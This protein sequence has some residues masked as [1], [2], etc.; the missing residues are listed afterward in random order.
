MTAEELARELRR[1][2]DNAPKGEQNTAVLLFGSSTQ[3]TCRM[4]L[5]ELPMLFGVQ[6]CSLIGEAK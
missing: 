1:M 4:E 2:Y 5:V 6:N 3:P